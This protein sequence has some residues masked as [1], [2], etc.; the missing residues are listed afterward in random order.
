MP[1]CALFYPEWSI[2]DPKFLFESLLYWDRLGCIVPDEMFKPENAVWAE[3]QEME[4]VLKEANERFVTPYLLTDE[5]KGRAHS[6]IAEFA[7]HP[8]P[9]TLRPEHLS[10]RDRSTMSVLKLA[11]KTLELLQTNRWANDTGRDDM[12]ELSSAAANLVMAALI[13]E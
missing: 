2:N 6:R 9:R 7:A 11:P 5:Q 13:D 8:A 4:K 10:S 12:T 1:I 3:D